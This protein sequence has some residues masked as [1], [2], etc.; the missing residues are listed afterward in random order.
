MET[1]NFQM[2]IMAS[3]ETSARKLAK[4]SSKPRTTRRV[5]CSHGAKMVEN[6]G[7][8]HGGNAGKLIEN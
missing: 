6:D 5:T 4:R 2:L 7:E 8:N 1:L 3:R